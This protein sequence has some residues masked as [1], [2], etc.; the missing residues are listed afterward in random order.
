[1]TMMMMTMMTMMMMMMMILQ[2]DVKRYGRKTMMTMV[3]GVKQIAV[4]T[5]S[6]S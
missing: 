6:L 4:R 3:K 1:M 5:K 2:Y